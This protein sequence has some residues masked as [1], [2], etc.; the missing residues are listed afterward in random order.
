[1]TVSPS[2]AA[3]IPCWIVLKAVSH[4]SPLPDPATEP[5]TYHVSAGAIPESENAKKISRKK[6]LALRDKV[7][8]SPFDGQ[9]WNCVFFIS[10]FRKAMLTDN[11]RSDIA[12]C[13]KLP[14]MGFFAAASGSGTGGG[15]RLS[16]PAGK[17]SHGMG[18]GTGKERFGRVVVQLA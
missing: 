3:S 18:G 12:P 9:W 14:S 17:R 6:K 11:V 16:R 8:T 15:A 4:V 2:E 1:M 13:K 10:S 7:S 5:S